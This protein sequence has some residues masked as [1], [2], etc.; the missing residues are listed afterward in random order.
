MFALPVVMYRIVITCSFEDRKKIT[1]ARPSGYTLSCYKYKVHPTSAVPVSDYSSLLT[2]LLRAKLVSV[3]ALAL[4]A[5]ACLWVHAGVAPAK[6]ESTPC[7]LS[8]RR[9]PYTARQGGLIGVCLAPMPVNKERA[10]VLESE[11]AGSSK[12]SLCGVCIHPDDHA[13]SEKQESWANFKDPRFPLSPH[14]SLMSTRGRQTY[15]RQMSLSWLYFLARA[16]REGSMIPPRRRSTKSRVDSF[17]M[18]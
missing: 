4:A 2:L 10:R 18:L 6:R 8:A 13:C 15:L 5:V 16:S 17:W 9:A 14:I 11:S 1:N 3:S 7:Q 12:D